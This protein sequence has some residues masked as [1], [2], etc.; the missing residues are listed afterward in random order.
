[1]KIAFKTLGCKLNQYDT[2]LLR[3]MAEEAL[4]E[5]TDFNDTADIYV[6]NICSVTM[7]AV[8]QSRNIVRRARRKSKGAKIIVT[9]CYPEDIQ[10]LLQEV[11]VYVTNSEKSSF[12]EKFFGLSR[13]N[14]SRFAEHTRAFV[15]IQS[16]CNRF[17]SYCIVPYLRGKEHSRSV[18]EIKREIKALVINGFKEISLTG[19]HIG[20]YSY[21]GKNLVKLLKEIEQIEPLERIR[22]GSL[23]PEEISEELI[24][25]VSVSEKICHHFHISLQS[26][27]K[28][29]LRAMGRRY[30]HFDVSR[31]LIEINELIPDCSIGADIITGFPSEQ[32]ME[33]QNTY[34][35]I[36]GLPF[37]YL[38]IFRYSPRKSTL[39]AILPDKV[40]EL[41]KKR[42]SELLRELALQK[43]IKFRE[44]Y[45]GKNLRVLVETKRDRKTKM[46]V[47]FSGNY[48]RVLIPE[49]E[50]SETKFRDVL[51]ERISGYDTYGRIY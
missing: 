3:E 20:R 36:K 18:E 41:Q 9:G 49:T 42:R 45:I 27:D 30:N 21:K 28:K 38:H 4:Y 25:Y 39:A 50:N 13:K 51:I 15:K 31:K 26:A 19:V 46:M 43:S 48:I 29:I 17:C 40:N 35:Y 10:E 1:M 22:L 47:G 37:T 16:G 7:S 6:I 2:Q 11:D 34:D 44:N 8:Q 33:F 24:H 5:I 14:I 23:N 32:E 12:F